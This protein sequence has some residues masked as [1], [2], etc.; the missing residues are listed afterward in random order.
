MQDRFKFKAVLKTSEFTILVKPYYI[1]EDSYFIDINQAETEFENKYPE[2][3]FWDFIDE[4]KK[5]D[6]I[7]EISS[8]SDLIITKDF[9]NLIQCTG[10]KDHT[11][12]LI[13]ESD[14]VKLSY[15]GGQFTL[16][17]DKFSENPEPDYFLVEWSDDWQQYFCHQ[18]PL[19]YPCAIQLEKLHKSF[20]HDLYPNN[21]DVKAR[22]ELNHAILVNDYDKFSEVIGNRYEN[23]E[24]LERDW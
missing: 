15:N 2:E 5:Q 13:F 11:G 9:T 14:I 19:N 8:D 4:I 21:A 6:Y 3:C 12:K 23:P 22:R 16:F 7:Q 10:L 20:E 24:L 18:L 1:L 17:G